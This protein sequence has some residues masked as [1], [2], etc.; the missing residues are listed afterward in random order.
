MAS[1]G[2]GGECANH[3]RSAGR[4]PAETVPH[5]V[6]EPAADQVA[7]HGIAHRTGN[8]EADAH[9]RVGCCGDRI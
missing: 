1:V 7:V 8:D 9:R 4:Q 3:D 6:A 2:G 5:Q